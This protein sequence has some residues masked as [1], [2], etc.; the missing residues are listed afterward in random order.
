MWQNLEKK[1]YRMMSTNEIEFLLWHSPPAQNPFFF[2][3]CVCDNYNDI[4]L[5]LKFLSSYLQDSEK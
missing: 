3:V 4:I 5:L 2:F 1:K